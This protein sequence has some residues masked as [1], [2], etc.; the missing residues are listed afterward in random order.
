MVV[1]LV[2]LL[3]LQFANYVFTLALINNNDNT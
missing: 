2:N 3:G 1:F